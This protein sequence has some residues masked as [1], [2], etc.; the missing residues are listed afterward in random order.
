MHGRV[1][2]V[3]LNPVAAAA[4][5]PAPAVI[6]NPQQRVKGCDWDYALTLLLRL[7]PSGVRPLKLTCCS[8]WLAAVLSRMPL[9]CRAT[10]RT[11]RCPLCYACILATL[12]ADQTALHADSG[13]CVLSAVTGAEDSKPNADCKLQHT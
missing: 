12:Q 10:S 7:V 8:S 11:R 1:P 6:P 13:G 4:A 2:L 9:P 3:V 5:L